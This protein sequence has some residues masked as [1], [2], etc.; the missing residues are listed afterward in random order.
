MGKKMHLWAWEGEGGTPLPAEMTRAE[1]MSQGGGFPPSPEVLSLTLYSPLC[2]ILRLKAFYCSL[3]GGDFSA[4]IV[5]AQRVTILF[6]SITITITIKSARIIIMANKK[7]SVLF[8]VKLKK[9]CRIVIF[10]QNV[11]LIIIP[12]ICL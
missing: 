7:G 5:D 1:E 4:L 12:R 9:K 6:R 11:I 8:T 3:H 2:T 10:V